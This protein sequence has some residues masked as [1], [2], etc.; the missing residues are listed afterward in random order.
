MPD[1]RDWE[2]YWK[3]E[4]QCARLAELAGFEE[5]LRDLP[6]RRDVRSLGRLLGTVIREQAGERVFEAEEALRRLAILHRRERSEAPAGEE[7]DGDLREKTREVIAGLPLSDLQQVVKAFST[8]FELTNIAE[9]IHRKRRLRGAELLPGRPD[10][11]GS[12]RGTLRRIREN[13]I[14]AGTALELLRRIEVT[15]VFTA[16]PTE[17]A[18]RVVL[19]KR[20]RIAEMLERLDRLPLSDTDA[21]REQEAILA[22]I[23]ALWQTDEVRRRKPTVSDEIRM[24]LNHY[25]D[26]LLPPLGPFYRFMASAFNAVFGS[27]VSPPELQTVIRF[28]SW[29]GGDRDGNPSVTPGCTVDAVARAR[30]LILAYYGDEAARLEELLTES[31]CR[32]GVPPEVAAAAAEAQKGSF[33]PEDERHPE[34]EPYRDLAA[35]IRRRLE[36]ALDDPGDPEAYA[37]AAELSADL[38]V[39]RNGLAAGKGERVAEEH[40][41]PF[42]RVV[43]TCGIHLQTLDIRQHARIHSRAVEELAAGKESAV[44]PPAPSAATLELLE[45]MRTL[46]E[47]KRTSPKTVTRY[48]ISGTES[49]RD[50]VNV[51]RLAELGGLRVAAAPDGSDP[52]LMPVPLFESIADLRSAGATCRTLW[53]M[54]AYAPYLESWGMRQEVMLG[55]S[56]SNKDGGMLTSSWELFKAQRELHLVAEECGVRLTLFH[57][58]GGTVGRGGGPSHRAIAAQPSGSFTGSMRV[59]EQGE[60]INWKYSDPILAWRNL[61]LLVAASLD[62]LARPRGKGGEPAPAWESALEEMSEDAFR[63]YRENIAENPDIVPYFDQATPV[64]EFD[65]A[66]IGSRPA[67]RAESRDLSSLR[68]I[69][70]GFGWMQSRHVIPG[71]FGVGHALCGFAGRGGG[72]ALLREMMAGFP[73]FSDLIRN[74]ELALSKVDLSIARL[75]ADLVEDAGIRERV[76]SMVSEEYRRT[77]DAVLAVTGQRRIL[78]GNQVLERSLRLRNPYVDPLSLIQV[79]LLRRKRSGRETPDVDYVLA[80]TISGIAAGLRNT[81]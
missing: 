36:A 11:P 27:S 7:G 54:P 70:W 2:I 65:L 24:G 64:L 39:I 35:H 14:D 9:T 41:D 6:L 10:K 57:G 29:I 28:G 58:R 59:T 16:H 44:L 40:V 62:V 8:F 20:H 81:G 32:V 1:K 53:T 15:P 49:P 26:V 67:R 63:F 19:F 5:D 76:F 22:E 33:G 79:E 23:T 12:L 68:A 55:Y 46:A 48:V 45:T 73:F 47:V 37:D 18:R 50:I 34:W 78:E 77:R 69:P 72:E 43:G 52:G 38:L 31:A 25:R 74:V 56:D 60:V 80:A 61:E 13:G 75:Y 4:D 30:R 66:K 21:A 17:V 3:V 71:W 42:L 51:V